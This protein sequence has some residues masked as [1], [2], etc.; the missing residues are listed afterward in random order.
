MTKIV[1]TC[2][3][4]G[5]GKGFYPS[6]LKAKGVGTYCSKKCKDRG[7][8]MKDGYKLLISWG[9]PAV[10]KNGYVR[11]H[12]LIMERHLGRYLKED[13]V[14]DHINGDRL[15]N[16]IENLRVCTRKEN[17]RNQRLHKNNSS[18]YK[19]VVWDKQRSKWIAQIMVDRKHLFLGR[20]ETVLEAAK[21]YDLS[22]SKYFGDFSLTNQL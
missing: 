11:E 20:F 6:E 16:R 8:Y 4:C 1:K 3:K 22:S 7:F 17:V 10:N 5:K 15:D 21:A 14:I 13:E 9:H 12:R 18:G 2:K 19:G